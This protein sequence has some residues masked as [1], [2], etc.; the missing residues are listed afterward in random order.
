MS[1]NGNNILSLRNYISQHITKI[2]NTRYPQLTPLEKQ[3][4]LQIIFKQIINN[5]RHITH[6]T[7]LDKYNTPM[8]FLFQHLKPEIVSIIA[9]CSDNINKTYLDKHLTTSFDWNVRL[10]QCMK[11]LNTKDIIIWYFLQIPYYNPTPLHSDI[12]TKQRQ[13]YEQLLDYF[14][15]NSQG[16]TESFYL[17]EAEFTFI[18]NQTCMTYAIAYHNQNNATILSKYCRLLRKICPW[19]NYYSP[20]L[21]EKV[22]K[23]QYDKGSL[24]LKPAGIR[25]RV[26]FISDSFVVDSSVLRDRIPV[27]GKLD[28]GRFDVYVA[29]FCKMD[30]VTGVIAGVFM[31]RFKDRYIYLGNNLVDARIAL[32]K[33]EF[34]VIVY[35]DLG[36]KLL[37]T[38]LAYSRIARVQVNTWGHSETCG[39]DTVDYFVSSRWFEKDL[40]EATNHYTEKLVLF[41]SLGTYYISPSK[42]FI[43]NN[44]RLQGK[45]VMRSREELGFKV[46]E[47][48]YCCLQTFYKINDEFE[49]CIAR[50]LELDPNG[51]V[52]LSNSYP[53]CKNHLERMLKNLGENKIKRVK[54]YP[55]LEKH[56][57]LNLVAV[58]DVC[59]DPFPF[60]GCN[61]SYD[62]FDFNVPVITW[63]GDYLHGRFTVGLYSRMGLSDCECIVTDGD[64]YAR[65]A[66]NIGV[67]DK[68][69]HKINR[70]IEMNKGK[71]F[72][73]NESVS[74]WN[75]WL[76]GI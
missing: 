10:F 69:R 61:T 26:C 39:I 38:L 7:E 35:P 40:L 53:F 15:D 34:D 65:I 73:E 32:E 2:I 72:Q 23:R 70:N 64:S 18:C 58:S 75:E 36:M 71:I 27:I 76:D 68:L 63:P 8:G 1:S 45:W 5:I 22:L 30:H 12:L 44:P 66:S 4:K 52:L 31:N 48:I 50:I 46:S 3:F 11:T 17:T 20:K 21:A 25:K 55:S 57:F 14:L 47:H 28:K 54:W 41:N 59:L 37:P 33:Y 74:E 9:N 62:A 60:G 67:N 19:L 13:L 16:W 42:L 51:V 49:R 56:I 29:S 43:D 6:T 24:A